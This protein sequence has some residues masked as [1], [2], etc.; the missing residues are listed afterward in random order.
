MKKYVVGSR[1]WGLLAFLALAVC[2]LTYGYF[3]GQTQRS[4]PVYQTAR[5]FTVFIHNDDE[6]KSGTGW[7]Y[8]KGGRYFIV[9]ANHVVS[10]GA[11]T[12]VFFDDR[13]GDH[14][15]KKH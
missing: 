6:N 12:Y 14:K 8:Q 4:A 2:F 7:I 5:R 10:D 3:L 13:S 11:D 9:T 1:N 15:V